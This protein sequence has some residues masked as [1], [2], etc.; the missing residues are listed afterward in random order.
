MINRIY[1]RL[2]ATYIAINATIKAVCQIGTHYWGTMVK[3]I[4][5][6]ANSW[7]M[8]SCTSVTSEEVMSVKL[9]WVYDIVIS[10]KKSS[11]THIMVSYLCF[12]SFKVRTPSL[13]HRTLFPVSSK[14]GVSLKK[15][16]F[17]PDLE[18][19]VILKC[20]GEAV[21]KYKSRDKQ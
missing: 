12:I 16:N 20:L 21:R 10:N 8:F 9:W 3:I 18:S 13:N 4:K 7:K 5:K 2:Y 11:Y 15:K 1:I 17:F 19:K 14:T 6:S